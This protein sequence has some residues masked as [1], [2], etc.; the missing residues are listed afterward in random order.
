MK[1]LLTGVFTI[2]TGIV[3]IVFIFTIGPIFTIMALNTLFGL[4][5]PLNIW[6][7]LS[8]FWLTLIVTAGARNVKN[9]EN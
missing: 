4:A 6:T 5:I 9:K 2:L 8:V 1:E 7:W 3:L